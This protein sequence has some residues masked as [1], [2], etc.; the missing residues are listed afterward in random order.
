MSTSPLGSSSTS[1]WSTCAAVALA[2]GAIGYVIGLGASL[3]LSRGGKPSYPTAKHEETEDEEVDDSGDEVNLTDLATVKAKG[4]EPCKLVLV[5]RTDLQM[6]KGKIAAQ[7]GHATLACYK[8]VIKGNPVLVRHWERTGQAKIAVRC[9]SEEELLILQ[10]TAKSLGICARSIQ[11][12]GR[13]QVASGST[14]V[15][16]IGPAPVQLVNQVTQHLKLL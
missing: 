5:V 6:T 1:F 2:S 13:T 16:G 7:C 10:A 15:L 9:D 14:T 4:D 3:P 8:S 11:D 12:A